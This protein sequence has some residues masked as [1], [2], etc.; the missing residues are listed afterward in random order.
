MTL[1]GNSKMKTSKYKTQSVTVNLKPEL[2]DFVRD[3][4]KA[5]EISMNELINNAVESYMIQMKGEP[6]DEEIQDCG[7]C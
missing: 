2:D 7:R 1:G 4:S 5:L 6:V 3:F